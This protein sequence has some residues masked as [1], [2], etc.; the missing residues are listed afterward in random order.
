MR[1]IN[2]RLLTF[3]YFIASLFGHAAFDGGNE[4]KVCFIIFLYLKIWTFVHSVFKIWPFQQHAEC[5]T[6]W[7][8]LAVVS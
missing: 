6:P 3:T 2:L 5:K 1:Y 7:I 4:W 8:I